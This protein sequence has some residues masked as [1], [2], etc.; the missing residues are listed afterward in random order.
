MALENKYAVKNINFHILSLTSNEPYTTQI[1]T[2]SE[3]Y[4]HESFIKYKRTKI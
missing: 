3:E 1:I 2:L 4:K